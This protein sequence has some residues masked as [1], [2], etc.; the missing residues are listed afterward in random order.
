MTIID[1]NTV[2]KTVDELI[3][4][5]ALAERKNLTEQVLWAVREYGD[6]R[7]RTIGD[8]VTKMVRDQAKKT[9]P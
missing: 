8:V 6:W 2:R 4:E 1:E 9:G 7:I 3:P 5:M